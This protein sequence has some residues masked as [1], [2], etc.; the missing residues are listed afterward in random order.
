MEDKKLTEKESLE[1]ISQMIRN[2][3]NRMEDNNGVPFLIWGYTTVVI[4]L[5]VWY[6][7][8]TTQDYHWNWLWFGIPVFA[9]IAWLIFNANKKKEAPRVTTFVDRVIGHVWM[10][11]G[12]MAF[13]VSVMTFFYCI[14]ILFIVLLTMGVATAITG[15]IIRF[16][17]IVLSGFLG[18]GLSLLCLI[19]KGSDAILVFAAAFV[20]MMVIP[21]HI[22]NIVSKKRN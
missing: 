18:M 8:T 19:V 21:G 14:P 7:L 15:L 2:T 13:L 11:F 4:A 5:L 9:G 3:R 20:L 1:L 6:M 12:I 17:P 22:L 16:K 10:V